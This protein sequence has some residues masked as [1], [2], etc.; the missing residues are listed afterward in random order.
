MDKLAHSAMSKCMCC[1]RWMIVSFNFE[2]QALAL[3]K[4]PE[5]SARHHFKVVVSQ[6]SE[7]YVT[8]T[9]FSFSV[10]SS[11]FL[12]FWHVCVQLTTHDI[13]VKWSRT[14]LKGTTAYGRGESSS[15]EVAA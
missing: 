8:K 12:I 14:K 2:K 10:F 3:R 11:V 5:I 9:Q 15:P 1:G 13:V 4:T 7:I 6:C